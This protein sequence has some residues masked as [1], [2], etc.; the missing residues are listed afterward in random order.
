M[1]NQTS[2][3]TRFTT[4]HKRESYI[5][6][7]VRRDPRVAFGWILRQTDDSI[8]FKDDEFRRPVRIPLGEVESC[9][10]V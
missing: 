10:A 3:E 7:C 8:L 6:I 2:L 4:Y 5:W 1:L 9:G